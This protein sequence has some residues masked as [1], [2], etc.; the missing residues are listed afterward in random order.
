MMNAVVPLGP[1]GMME[2]PEE[3]HQGVAEQLKEGLFTS[4]PRLVGT[5]V[6]L[7]FCLAFWFVLLSTQGGSKSYEMVQN[8]RGS[9]G[10]YMEV[11]DA[12]SWFDFMEQ[13]FPDV[14]F[15]V[16]FYNG[17]EYEREDLGN[18]AN[19]F[20]LVGAVGIRQ[21]RSKNN[22]CGLVEKDKIFPM[23][24]NCF[25]EYS[26]KNEDKVPYG[27]TVE[28]GTA[29]MFTWATAESLGCKVGCS[30]VGNLGIT[31]QG[32]GFFEKLPSNR[33][34]ETNAAGG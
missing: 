6:Y 21:V 32:G 34:A 24:K 2:A 5:L 12:A 29:R 30:T 17:D 33:T 15:P 1:G 18:V 28:P 10:S 14:V 25:G 3:H 11:S 19:S 4:N 20:M 27:P 22:T 16:E 8:I 31:Y 7:V 26:K 23:V 13:T 9:L